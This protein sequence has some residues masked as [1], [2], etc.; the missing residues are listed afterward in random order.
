ME[1][2]NPALRNLVNLGKSYEKS[3]TGT[4]PLCCEDYCIRLVYEESVHHILMPFCLLVTAMNLAGKAYFDAVSK[5]GENAAVSPVSRELG[6]CRA[7][8]V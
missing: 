5:I 6:K 7:W 1:N 4:V 2:F 8:L 3:V